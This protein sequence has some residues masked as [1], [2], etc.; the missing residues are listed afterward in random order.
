MLARYLISLLLS[1]GIVCGFLARLPFVT[2]SQ[3]SAGT[4]FEETWT[5]NFTLPAV[6]QK[7]YYLI[8]GKMKDYLEKGLKFVGTGAARVRSATFKLNQTRVEVGSGKSPATAPGTSLVAQVAWEVPADAA[9]GETGAIHIEFP[10]FA[11]VQRVNANFYSERIQKTGEE[12]VFREVTAYRS[13][14]SLALGRYRFASVAGLSIVFFFHG[15]WWLFMIAKE[16]RVRLAA[17][18][19]LSGSR[20]GSAFW[21]SP[22]GTWWG[23]TLP[24]VLINFVGALFASIS[25]SR[26]FMSPVIATVPMTLQVSSVVVA[27][28][29]VLI[30]MAKEDT[31]TNNNNSLVTGHW[32]RGAPAS[33]RVK[34]RGKT[35]GPKHVIAMLRVPF[36]LRRLEDAASWQ[37]AQELMASEEVRELFSA[38]AQATDA[39]VEPQLRPADHRGYICYQLEFVRSLNEEVRVSSNTSMTFG[40]FLFP[41]PKIYV[42]SNVWLTHQ[43]ADDQRDAGALWTII[44]LVGVE[45]L[46]GCMVA[47]YHAELLPDVLQCIPM[48][49]PMA[50]VVNLVAMIVWVIKR[51]RARRAEAKRLRARRAEAVRCL[52]ESYLKPDAPGVAEFRKFAE[53]V[54]QTLRNAKGVSVGDV[55]L[56]SDLAFTTRPSWLEGLDAEIQPL[57]SWVWN[58]SRKLQEERQRLSGMTG[59]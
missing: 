43:A 49:I 30:A 37:T 53:G 16:R 8:E 31:A 40:Y 9:D 24:L 28:V 21:P 32:I 5:A 2:L 41:Q 59:A 44:G 12:W 39:G 1:L 58:E 13:E 45:V 22:T 48:A 38:L 27:V 26:D 52:T 7:G 47:Y 50:M 51:L 55:A 19:Q 4:S 17:L 42:V 46:A 54:S 56:E 29:V 33:M 14:A 36:T 3:V 18:G 10:P 35:L 6:T 23:W 20:P 11:D 15:I 25:I 57:N 34:A